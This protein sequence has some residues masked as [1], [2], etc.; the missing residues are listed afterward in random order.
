MNTMQLDEGLSV[1]PTSVSARLSATVHAHTRPG[2]LVVVPQPASE[3]PPCTAACANLQLDVQSH[4]SSQPGRHYCPSQDTTSYYPSSSGGPK[5]QTPFLRSPAGRGV[6]P[7]GP[8][9]VPGAGGG[10]HSRPA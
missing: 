9:A 10:R 8:I 4:V 7:S 1:S 2:L 5:Y 6:L 3:Q